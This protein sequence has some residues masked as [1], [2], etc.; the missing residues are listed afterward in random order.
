MGRLEL[1]SPATTRAMEKILAT[2]D[3]VALQKY[4]RFPES[5]LHVRMDANPAGPGN[6]KEIWI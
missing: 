6:S 1:L 2:H 3:I 5:I 4:D